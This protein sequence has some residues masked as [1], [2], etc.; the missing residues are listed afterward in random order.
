M[1][2]LILNLAIKVVLGLILKHTSI[3]HLVQWVS[4]AEQAYDNAMKKKGQVYQLLKD[5][6]GSTNEEGEKQTALLNLATEL[7][8]YLTKKL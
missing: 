8:V 2:T 3:D 7:G 4:D 5:S 1:T 6:E